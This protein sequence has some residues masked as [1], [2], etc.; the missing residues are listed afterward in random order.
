MPRPPNRS[1]GVAFFAGAGLG[2]VVVLA[3]AWALIDL[4]G[5]ATPREQRYP[6]YL[7]LFAAV[8]SAGVA[9]RTMRSSWLRVLSLAVIG[10]I[11]AF[12]AVEIVTSRALTGGETAAYRDMDAGI[13]LAR[14]VWRRCVPIAFL[15]DMMGALIGC[16]FGTD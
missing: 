3:A 9:A 2:V 11:C 15:T 12:I 4:V 10:F 5:F 1:R 6:L 14:I 7:P 8:V 13:P 16:A